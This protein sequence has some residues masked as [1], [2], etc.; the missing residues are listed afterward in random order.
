MMRVEGVKASAVVV[1]EERGG[2]KRLIG[3]VEME[4]GR[5]VEGGEK[6]GREIRERIREEL[7]EYEVP[8]EVVVVERMPLTA[9]GKVDK[10]ELR[11]EKRRGERGGVEEKERGRTAVEEVVAGIWEEVLGVERVGI[12]ESFFDLGGHSLKA[13]ELVAKLRSTFQVD[14]PMRS[15][16]DAATVAG[17]SKELIAIES[18]P[19]Q[20][21]KIA[22]LVKKIQDM[23]AGEVQHALHSRR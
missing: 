8:A 2:E 15:L 11:K 10:K 6:V 14:L 22:Q 20:L 3:Y 12:N 18:K 5:E 13:L 9:H 1:E 4:E 17:I 23:S 16:F 7:P 21:E 19:G